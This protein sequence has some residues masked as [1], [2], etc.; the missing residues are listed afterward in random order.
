MS[1]DI[2]RVGSEIPE[3]VA[4][5]TRMPYTMIVTFKDGTVRE[6]TFT[7]DDLTGVFEPMKD[8]EYFT[9]AFVDSETKTVVWPNGIDLDP[10]VLYEP[11]LRAAE[12]MSATGKPD[13]KV[14]AQP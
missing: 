9:R 11:S 6:T 13:Q 5:A 1:G 14:G 7:S 8:P 2:I 12:T 4:V 10:C 3:V